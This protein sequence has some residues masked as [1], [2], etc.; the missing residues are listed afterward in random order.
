[1]E[2]GPLS[3]LSC[4]RAWDLADRIGLLLRDYEY[5][6]QDTLIQPWLRHKLGL[7]GADP[8]H[9]MMERAQRA[10]FLDITREPDGKRALLNRHSEQS[11]K[12]F[13]QYAM[14][15]MTSPDVPTPTGRTIHFFGFTQI[16]EL[17][18]RTIA[19]L[20]RCF[21]VRFYHLNVLSSRLG[22]SDDLRQMTQ[23]F[24]RPF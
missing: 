10:M 23:D 5:A 2:K 22:G 18:A 21:D 15:R 11:F 9:Q 4:R 16:C 7:S 20:G 6:R 8:F 13:P 1:M 12:T 3:R 19:W 24:A 14:E 17:H